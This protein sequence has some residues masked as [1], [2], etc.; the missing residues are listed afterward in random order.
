MTPC[1]RYWGDICR[2]VDGD[3][4]RIQEAELKEH[5]SVCSDCAEAYG[6][7]KQLRQHLKMM[8]SIT[9]RPNF[10][11]LLHERLRWEK[12]HSPRLTLT[13]IFPRWAALPATGLAFLLLV[14]GVWYLSTRPV[15]LKDIIS[16]NQTEV[17]FDENEGPQEVYYVIE[18]DPGSISL[19]RDDSDKSKRGI[20]ADSM[21]QDELSRFRSHL[22]Q[23][24]F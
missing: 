16:G 2:S 11:I 12:T 7:L 5:L 21:Q 20:A 15:S 13:P 14:S 1:K 10:N 22:R 18:D 24:S 6:R 3:L 17:A 8:P 19:S 9:V 4:D 23:V